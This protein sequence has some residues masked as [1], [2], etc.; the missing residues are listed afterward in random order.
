VS[1]YLQDIH[2]VIA[3]ERMKPK[4]LIWFG[5]LHSAECIHAIAQQVFY[6]RISPAEAK[7]V[8]D[9][10]K[11]DRA[12]GLFQETPTP[13]NAFDQCADLGRRYAPELGM[14][15]LDSL[16]VACA[17]ELQA[18]RFWTFDQ[19]QAKLAKIVGLKTG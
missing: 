15:T 12:A 6:R 10:L 7:S 19:R 17:L 13:E 18:E 16:H 2:S 4:P 14:R 3:R 1:L 8:F 5:P 11:R 9:I